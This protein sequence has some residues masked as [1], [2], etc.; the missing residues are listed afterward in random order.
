MVEQLPSGEVPVDHTL[1]AAVHHRAHPIPHLKANAQHAVQ[2]AKVLAGN[3]IA[4][5]RGGQLKP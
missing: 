2:K 3:I 5:G 4:V 1:R